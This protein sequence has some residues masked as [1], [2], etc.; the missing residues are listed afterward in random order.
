M[1]DLFGYGHGKKVH[2]RLHKSNNWYPRL[3]HIT[4]RGSQIFSSLFHGT[5]TPGNAVGEGQ[6]MWEGGGEGA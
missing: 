3:Y 2:C 6:S 1:E 4:N 5:G